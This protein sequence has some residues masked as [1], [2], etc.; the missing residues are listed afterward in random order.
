MDIPKSGA[1][2]SQLFT[3]AP[4]RS[5]PNRYRT[6]TQCST[7]VNGTPVESSG[8]EKRLSGM[9]P[10]QSR[11][12]QRMPTC[13]PDSPSRSEHRFQAHISGFKAPEASS[14][15]YDNVIESESDWSDWTD[16]EPPSEPA[17]E[18]KR[19]KSNVDLA[20]S[21]SYLTSG[22]AKIS[23]GKHSPGSR[24]PIAQG[25]NTPEAESKKSSGKG[26][27]LAG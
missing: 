3:G 1:S 26:D 21:P 17:L 20:S 2:S 18:F 7:N 27:T 13:R 15:S 16:D 11:D 10:P 19:V 24:T 5:S 8:L 6:D 9:G 23:D 22:L 12:Q 4:P 14:K 25:A